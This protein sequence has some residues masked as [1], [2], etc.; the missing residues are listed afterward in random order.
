MVP[1]TEC[2]SPVTIHIEVSTTHTEA[3]KV[4]KEDETVHIAP[5]N[6]A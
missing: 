4:H 1:A 6:Y 2:T 3:A 5:V